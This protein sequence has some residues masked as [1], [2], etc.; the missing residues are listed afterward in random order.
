MLLR[1]RVFF[2][3]IFVIT[4][5]NWLGQIARELNPDSGQGILGIS[6]RIK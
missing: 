2:I 5:S 4:E 6:R 1:R 3:A